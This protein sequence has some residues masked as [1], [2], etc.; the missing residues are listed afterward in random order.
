MSHYSRMW[1]W[2]R[3]VMY[4]SLWPHG[5]EPARLLHPWDFPGKNTGVGCHFLTA[6]WLLLI[7]KDADKCSP[8]LCSVSLNFYVKT[9]VN[10]VH[11]S[12]LFSNFCLFVLVTA[13]AI[14]F[15]SQLWLE[16]IIWILTGYCHAF[17]IHIINSLIY[18]LSHKLFICHINLI[19]K[20]RKWAVFTKHIWTISSVI[21]KTL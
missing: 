21:L 9:W 13:V 10:W 17:W 18:L 19:W 4:D 12:Y 16:A 3:S 15:P 6:G 11:I 7:V 14:F 2:S 5:L 8:V 20:T 1:K